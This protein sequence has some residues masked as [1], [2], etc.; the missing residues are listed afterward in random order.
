MA[1][2]SAAGPPPPPSPQ[3]WI[4]PGK[5]LATGALA[6]FWV[7]SLLTYG[8]L[9]W[10]QGLEE[11]EEGAIGAPAAERQ[12]PSATAA[13]TSQPHLIFIL[14]DDQGFRDVGYHGSEIKTPTL[15]KLA[16]EGVKLEN[17]YV[18]P[19]CTPSR[20]QFITGKYQIHTGLQHSI[21]RPTQP[22]CLPLDN[23]TLPQKLKEVGY[24]THMVG[25]WHLGFYRKECM[26]T[27]R[28]FD[29]FFGS[30]L[31][32]G[33]YYT[34]YKCD[35]PG[36][37]G[38]DLY[39]NDS[40]AWDH[41]NGIYSTQMYTQRVQQILASHNP[42]K[43]IFLYIAY[44]AVH[45]PLQAPG[46]YFE[47]YRS[48]I[49]INRRRYAA[50]LSCLD[51]A[52]NNVTLALKTYG[53]YNNS[54]LIYSSDNGGQPTAGGSNWPLRGSKGTYWEGGIRAVG[55]VHSPLLKN[56]GT[57][58]KELVH[59]TDWYPTLISL[60]EGQIDEDIQ[61]DGYD[62]WETI[63]EGLR[64]PRVDILHNI[65][66]IY[67]KAKNGSWAAGYGIWNTAIQSAI[68]VQHWKLLTG[69]PGY[70]DWVPPQSFSNL[71]PNRWHNERITL[72]TGKSVWL[73]NIT[74]DPYERVDLSS[75]YPGIVK[76]LLRRLSQFNKTA[77]PVRYPPKD[78]RSNP[79]LNGGVWGPW[80][81]EENKKKKPGRNKGTKKQKKNKAKKKK[82]QKAGASLNCHSAVTH[83]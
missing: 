14:A 6:G 3:A 37:C 57:V 52:V 30:L 11:E 36:M 83:G 26:P 16:A 15:D 27:K 35:S 77:V 62:I 9:S 63:S 74:A 61:L 2:R 31:G 68:R 65:D 4:C 73:F 66:P 53:F 67:T 13:T 71:G 8:Y 24:S 41:D 22:N 10:G 1:P 64:S 82:Q 20:S 59:I 45:S 80:Y 48:I 17:Y 78:P 23:A 55:F 79:R 21:I 5:M 12:E 49:N 50:M 34:H 40:A 56:K 72:S 81:K 69:N 29:T 19:I 38:Y 47:H 28:G 54:I 60:A 76:Q 46:R 7:L 43:P 39:E 44:Q 51:E 58:C 75:R 32:S 25:K 18:Q 42:T 33:D 70:S